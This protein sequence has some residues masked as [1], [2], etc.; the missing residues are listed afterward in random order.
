MRKKRVMIL[1]SVSINAAGD[2]V[3]IGAAANDGNG[4]YTGHVKI[5]AWN[6][7]S[8]TQQGQ[9]IDGENSMMSLD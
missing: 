5:Y 4:I 8:W 7:T 9:D 1:V 6:S 2:K 3:A